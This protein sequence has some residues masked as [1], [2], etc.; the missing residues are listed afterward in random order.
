MMSR[1][2]A[3]LSLALSLAVIVGCSGSSTSTKPATG[4]APGPKGDANNPMKVAPV[5]KMEAPPGK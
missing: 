1:V 4:G 5:E 3:C 2:F